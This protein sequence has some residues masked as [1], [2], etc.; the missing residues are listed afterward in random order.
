M[1]SLRHFSV[2]TKSC[3]ASNNF[4]N[5][6]KCSDGLVYTRPIKKSKNYILIIWEYKVLIPG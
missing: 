1:A 2:L 3:Y 5:T 6:E 4:S